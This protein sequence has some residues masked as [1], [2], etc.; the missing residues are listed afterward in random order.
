VTSCLVESN[1]SC[2]T[3]VHVSPSDKFD[4]KQVKA[5]ACAALYFEEVINALVPV[6]RLGNEYCKS[7]SACNE[8]FRGKTVAECIA[9]VENLSDIISVVN[10]MNPGRGNDRYY[11]WNFTNLQQGGTLTIEFGQGPGV[12]TA[13]SALMWAEFVVTFVGAAMAVPETH[14][15]LNQ[16]SND[17]GGLKKFLKNGLVP[18]VCDESFI[19]KITSGIKDSAKTCGINPG[20]RGRRCLPRSRR[21][22]RRSRGS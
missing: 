9:E 5:V 18:G 10:L 22:S 11:T 17:V 6:N 16:F 20:K 2:G 21:M 4:V 15:A 7:F 14:K 8:N 13:S 19:A 12:I 1:S 3:H